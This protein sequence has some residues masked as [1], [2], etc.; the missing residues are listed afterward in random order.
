LP[1]IPAAQNS[2]STGV[3]F[4]LD[5][6]CN[7]CYIDNK[8]NILILKTLKEDAM[9]KLTRKLEELFTDITFAEERAF[10]PAQKAT[11]GFTQTIEN[12][13]TAVAFSEAGEFEI[14]KGYITKDGEAPK[15]RRSGYRPKE[16]SRPCAGRA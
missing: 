8:H 15:S 16:F 3:I 2:D 7:R 13:F 9:K 6:L 10:K 14:E 12:F 11:G 5:K 1:G 4:V